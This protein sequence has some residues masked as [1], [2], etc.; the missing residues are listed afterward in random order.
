[1]S[2]KEGETEYMIQREIIKSATMPCGVS[3]SDLRNVEEVM[4][5]Y[6]AEKQSKAELENQECRFKYEVKRGVYN[7]R[8]NLYDATDKDFLMVGY[9]FAQMQL[10]KDWRIK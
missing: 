10:L 2:T 1:M 4:S 6:L 3:D 7:I 9:L 8:V 5:S